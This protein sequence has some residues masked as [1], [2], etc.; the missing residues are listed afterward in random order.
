MNIFKR[1]F[2]RKQ[3]SSNDPEKRI[4]VN[5][6][7][8]VL[9]N[10]SDN[11]QS[12]IARDI[13]NSTIIQHFEDH[14]HAGALV[15][16]KIN[17]DVELIRKSRFFV[18]FDT[19]CSTLALAK[20]LV[21]GEL[22][23]GSDAVRCRAI[24]WCS[25]LLSLKE[26]DKAEEYLKLG[27][28]LGSCPEIEIADAFICSQKGD[29]NTALSVLAGIELPLSRSAS[30]MVVSHHEDPQVTV[31]W[32]KTAGI[33][34]TDLDPDGRHFL[35][36]LY[37]KLGHWEVARACLDS[38]TS[39]DLSKT[40]ALHHMVAIIH[41]TSTVPNE[42]RNVVLKQL[43]FEAA[44]FPLAADAAAID[45][46]REAH[47]H[48]I[49]GAEV[50][51]QLNCP[52]AAIIDDEY[53]LWLELKDPDESDKG[54][55]RLEAKL[56]DTKSALRLVHLGLQFGIK[57]DLEVV[58]RE[59]ERQI[60][61]HGGITY[62]A[63]IAR[64][65]LA[66]TKKN[67]EDVANYI[68]RHRNELAKYFDKKSM[69]FIQI[70]ML[71][72]A[73]LPER[74]KECLDTLLEEGL[75]DEEES[76]L[77]R[78][79]AEAEGTNPVEARKEQFKKTDSLSDL[80][81]LVHEL[82]NMGEW[83]GLCEYG[84][85]LFER[86]RSLDDAV[87]L[88]NALTNTHKNERLVEF[89]KANSALLEQ[90]KN[91]QMLY[92]WGLYQEGALLRARSELSKLSDDRNNQNYRALQVNL[93]IALGDWN[94]LTALVANEYIEKDKRSAQELIGVAQLALHLDSPHAKELVF[95][96]AEK[97]N[98]D[99][100]ILAA[101]YFL[102]SSAGWEDDAKAFQ[103]LNKAAA[104]SGDDGPI[105]KKSLKDILNLQPDWD[106]R[107]TE[108]LQLLSH[109]DIP[110]FLAA[111]SLNRSLIHMMLFPAMSNLLQN[112]PRRRGVIPAYSGNRQ[113]TLLK[114]GG[115]VA[116]DATA[117]LTLSFLNLLDKALDAF[118]TIHIPHSTLSWLFEEKQKAAFH[119]PSRIRDAHQVHHLLATGVLEKFMPNTVP[120]SEL[121]AQIGDELALLIA[122]AEKVSYDNSTQRI[123]VRSSPVHRIASL[124]EEEADLTEHE[125][126]LSSCQAIVDKLRQKGQ[127]TAEEEKKA[128]FYFQLNEK[129]WP[130]QPEI[131][132]GAILYLDDVAVTYF[133]HLG[134][135]EKLKAAGFRLIASP[136]QV[137]E[138]NELI[139][140][141]GIS[142]KINNAI[143]CIRSAIN[144][145]IESG[146]IKV[147]KRRNIGE[148]EK[149]KQSISDHPTIGLIALASD[150]EAILADDRFLNQHANADGGSA[151]ASI[152][153]TLDL[154]DALVST[155]SI[156]V[157][158][159]WECRTLLRRAGYCFVPLSDEELAYHLDA[160]T[161]KDDK[162]IETAELKAIRENIL[163]VRMSTWLQLPKEAPWLDSLLKTFIRVLKGL[164]RSDADFSNIRV[165]SNWIISQID[166]RSWAQSFG[167]EAGDSIVKTGQGAYIL[168]LLSPPADAPLEV[169]D[170]YWNWI[171]DMV[172]VSIKE[173][174]PVLYSW[175]IK[176][177]RRIV[178]DMADM[179]L[180]KG[181]TT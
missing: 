12:F 167:S 119:Q 44:G 18:E 86:T 178:A 130:N 15:D 140:Y 56:R 171:E 74:A 104:L 23:C 78:I 135:L 90:S 142:G 118:D 37:L 103:W 46:R 17:D 134:I 111:Q 77:Q 139:S 102:A 22:S 120:D 36:T 45:A 177:Y 117:L 34:E 95:S 38:L 133:L 55:Q 41:L 164:W 71:S 26:L 170:E 54:R 180:S 65:A 11:L 93:G 53:A 25:R 66:F 83:D 31:D 141:K 153:S 67:S 149:H 73:G 29:K 98:G 131:A 162:V 49:V 43:P 165:R 7:D 80:A 127:I 148:L 94:S 181:V 87:N 147:G 169:K 6:E 4:Q 112:D 129:P 163:R 59:I 2:N 16:Q 39:D 125:A 166:V 154:L 9:K 92:C 24:A 126:I 179:D 156:S 115:A 158:D 40:P 91:L 173:Q 50:A 79:I 152:F 89:L 96:A 60:A 88:A 61:L 157:E 51:K 62:D 155:G 58:E 172:L 151:H 68:A 64:F 113:P 30:L 132:D 124:M 123:V 160:C 1:I 8:K 121:S 150:C 84:E 161:V 72:Q 20:R 145:R 143:E 13:K 3:V 138:A 52:N 57:L 106:R 159:R 63:A 100:G 176:C 19:V 144:L 33:N 81:F 28:T 21:E 168:L 146:K 35:L 128:R 27:R 75:S 137:S 175:L 114:T 109:G 47:H 85:M 136:R 105:Q 69:E 122:E 110:M 42:L 14:C 97:G 32:L 99:A 10:S 82:K 70:E 108:N 174:H 116:I 48:F 107:E 76:H 101:A 5:E